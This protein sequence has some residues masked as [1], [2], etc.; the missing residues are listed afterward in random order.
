MYQQTG[1]EMSNKSNF[2]YEK[3]SLVFLLNIANVILQQPETSQIVNF[4]IYQRWSFKSSSVRQLRTSDLFLAS[5]QEPFRVLPL[6]RL[7]LSH[8]IIFLASFTIS[9]KKKSLIVYRLKQVWI[10]IA[11][12]LISL[13]FCFKFNF[14]S[15]HLLI[16]FVPHKKKSGF[17][18]NS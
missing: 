6:Q 8:L 7:S 15:N 5:N 16:S 9:V 4:K 3:F 14:V 17:D 12:V 11:S 10:V 18:S 2:T 1:K 13:I